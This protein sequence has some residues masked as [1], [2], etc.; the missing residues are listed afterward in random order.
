MAL[1]DLVA[2]LKAEAAE[3]REAVVVEARERARRIRA[4]ADEAARRMR[5][6]AHAAAERE[7]RDE[8]RRA[9][10]RAR[11]ETA[12]RVLASRARL[13]ERVRDRVARRLDEA[14]SDPVYLRTL[15]DE[16]AAALARMPEGSAEVR[17]PEVLASELEGAAAG[18]RDVRIVPTSD[19][20]AGYTL[21]SSDGRVEIDAT[22]P[23]RLEL[24]WPRIAVRLVQ[25]VDG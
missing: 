20:P 24:R 4:E 11:M 6:E 13:L 9:V 17:V 8:A 3:Q 2:S 23:A 19:G 18:R 15:P 25:E 21:H 10:A 22:L 5:T 16:L 7:A 14:V 1:A 12:S